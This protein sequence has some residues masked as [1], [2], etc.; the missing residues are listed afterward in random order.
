MAP[1]PKM[2][3][4]RPCFSRGNDS[5]RIDWLMGTRPP[6]AS[7]WITRKKTRLFRLQAEPH[8]NEAKVNRAMDA[9]W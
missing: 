7:P 8:M 4:A 9:I 6:P 3:I 5:S 1:I 2:A